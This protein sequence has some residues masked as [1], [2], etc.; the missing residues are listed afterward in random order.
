MFNRE[1][2]QWN[3]LTQK[4]VWQQ[5]GQQSDY[6]P[7]WMVADIIDNNVQ[8][9]YR[10]GNFGIYQKWLRKCAD[11]EEKCW[12]RGYGLNPTRGETFPH[13]LCRKPVG[14]FSLKE[15]ED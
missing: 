8:I 11:I 10:M 9:E 13:Y 14:D 2:R 3:T 5:G 15:W 1:N 7:R 12:Q 6:L 4:R